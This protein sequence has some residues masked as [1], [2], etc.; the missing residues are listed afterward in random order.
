MSNLLKSSVR[1]SKAMVHDEQLAVVQNRKPVV[2]AQTTPQNDLVRVAHSIA[3]FTGSQMCS[4]S[5]TNGILIWLSLDLM[6][7]VD[8]LPEVQSVDR[9]VKLGQT[10]FSFG[11]GW[12]SSA[13]TESKQ[14]N[15]PQCPVLFHHCEG[16][17]GQQ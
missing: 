10:A 3:H 1:I 9:N 11:A 16:L 13:S 5:A 2:K 4:T 6:Q 14:R 7:P 12:H 17:A 15:L 8:T